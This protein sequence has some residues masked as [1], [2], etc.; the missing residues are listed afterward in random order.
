[1]GK[2]KQ[3]DLNIKFEDQPIF[4]SKGKSFAELEETFKELRKKFK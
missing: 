2:K 4:K 1:M 3:F